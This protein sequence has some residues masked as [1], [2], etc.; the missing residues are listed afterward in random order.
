MI[1]GPRTH[2]QDGSLIP[3]M[4]MSVA[5]SC[6]T[7]TPKQREH[8]GIARPWKERHRSGMRWHPRLSTKLRTPCLT[9]ASSGAR[10]SR[11]VTRSCCRRKN[12]KGVQKV[13]RG[14]RHNTPSLHRTLASVPPPIPSRISD[15]SHANPGGACTLE[16]ETAMRV[17]V[18]ARTVAHTLEEATTVGSTSVAVRRI[19]EEAGTV[20]STSVAVRC[21][22]EEARTAGSASVAGCRRVAVRQLKLD[23]HTLGTKRPCQTRHAYTPRTSLRPLSPAFAA[24]P[25]LATNP[26]RKHI[27]MLATSRAHRQESPVPNQRCDPSRPNIQRRGSLITAGRAC[28]IGAVL[29]P[30]PSL[31]LEC[32]QRCLGTRSLG[33]GLTGTTKTHSIE[34]A[35][36]LALASCNA[37][38]PRKPSFL[39]TV[40]LLCSC[41]FNGLTTRS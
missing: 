32:Y 7:A 8:K 27:A 15:M 24:T 2:S 39:R 16:P 1:S 22:P 31:S 14:S 9:T 18:V 36:P 11:N 12:R 23:N 4:K 37:L 29:G 5:R 20:G 26:Q 21:T 33:A 13:P 41:Q 19:P 34:P 35:H 30:P 6:P 38:N 25:Q 17:V 40:P 3:P 28:T 10:S